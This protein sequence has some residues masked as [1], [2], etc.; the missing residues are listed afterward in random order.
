[1]A[2][3]FGHRKMIVKDR[4]QERKEKERKKEKR[5]Q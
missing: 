4:A 2:I 5:S 3:P 1:M